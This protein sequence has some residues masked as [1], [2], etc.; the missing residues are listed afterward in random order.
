M[1][2]CSREDWLTCA[3]PALRFAGFRLRRSL[4]QRGFTLKMVGFL[5]A[6]GPREDKYFSFRPRGHT[7]ALR[8][9]CDGGDV[10][11]TLGSNWSLGMVP[12]CLFTAKA[13]SARSCQRISCRS[14]VSGCSIGVEYVKEAGASGSRT[15]GISDPMHTGTGTAVAENGNALEEAT[16]GKEHV[17]ASR[18]LP[19]VS[20][21]PSF[22]CGKLAAP[23]LEL[24]PSIIPTLN[25][26]H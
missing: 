10:P 24:A 9:L 11:P 16:D 3:T 18:H 25:V 23:M 6:S 2:A 5:T 17:A 1:V 26:P 4:P 15:P 20:T 21:L 7:G 19:L 8:Q 22:A 12:R 14:S 13:Q